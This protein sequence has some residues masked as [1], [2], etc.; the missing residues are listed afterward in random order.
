M[1]P[2]PLVYSAPF[3]RVGTHCSN[4]LSIAHAETPHY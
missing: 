1:Y 4:T 2:A 3:A